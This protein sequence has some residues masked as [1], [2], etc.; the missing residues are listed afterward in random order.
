M[1]NEYDGWLQGF[2]HTGVTINDIP[3]AVH[4]APVTDTLLPDVLFIH[5]ING[6]YHGL[7]PVAYELRTVCRAI[8]VDLPGHGETA[9]P[10]SDNVFSAVRGWSRQLL[11]VLHEHG[12][13]V[14]VAAGHSFGSFVAQE[15]GVTK[16]ALLN[17]PFA[18][19]ELSRRGTAVLD[20]AAAVVGGVYSSYPAMIRRG[21]WLMHKRTK[22]SDEIIAWSSRL[23]HVTS[24]Q[25][26]FQAHFAEIIT[27]VE[28]MDIHRLAA[29]Q[30]LLVVVA[31]YD[32]IVNNT[33]VPFEQLPNA[34][35]VTLPT[36]HVSIFEM[37][38][39]V[40]DEIRRIL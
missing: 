1:S 8:F 21:H 11:G 10:Q 3:T 22:Q 28:L 14:T 27:E 5:G 24:E 34:K 32:R 2:T 19:S 33:S 9:I 13:F 38:A 37:P 29:V 23:T 7:V 40:A 16:L 31:R 36:D 20:I 39:K 4:C 17:P 35:I 30:N 15:S 18:T 6:D 12:F 26:R 25:F